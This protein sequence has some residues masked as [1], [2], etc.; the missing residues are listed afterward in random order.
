MFFAQTGLTTILFILF[1]AKPS[2]KKKKF[3]HQYFLNKDFFFLL[4]DKKSTAAKGHKG[5]DIDVRQS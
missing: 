3:H 4:F 5:V 1:K 2:N